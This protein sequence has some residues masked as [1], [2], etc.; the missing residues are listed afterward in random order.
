ML[1]DPNRSLS[2]FFQK[3]RPSLFC[4]I[5]VKMSWRIREASGA[6]AERAAVGALVN[7]AYEVE[8][9]FKKTPRYIGT[10][11]DDDFDR[12]GA[13]FLIAENDA[14][15]II[16]AI[17]LINDEHGCVRENEGGE[18]EREKEGGEGERGSEKG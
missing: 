6:A 1:Y 15:G 12:K 11:V 5:P 7:A 10:D 14:D 16:G 4:E 2:A 9:F 13:T 8:D 17:Y 3:A 18:G